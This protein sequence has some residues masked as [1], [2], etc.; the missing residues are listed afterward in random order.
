MILDKKI[1][2]IEFSA[3]EG[4]CVPHAFTTRIGGMSNGIFDSLN[5]AYHR[6]DI[7][8]N[9][10]KNHARLAYALG[11]ETKNLVLAHQTHSDTVRVVTKRDCA[12]MDHHAYPECDALVTNDPGTALFVFTADCT[13][14]LFYDPVTGAVGAAHAGWRGTASAVGAKT[15]ETM[16]RA[17]GCKAENIRAAIGPNIGQCCFETNADV[18]DAMRAA[19]GSAAEEFIRM[20]YDKYYVNLKGINALSLRRVGVERIECSDVCT[21]CSHERY[22]SHRYTRG[23]RGSQG[24]VIVCKE[25]CV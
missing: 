14:L 20:E 9:V 21:M 2:A 8:E 7:P 4:I 22:W 5:L 1:D 18:P 10:E 16:M 23:A 19:Y 13:P 6:G 24:A 3:A 25:E 17:F 15:V 11:Y 12:G